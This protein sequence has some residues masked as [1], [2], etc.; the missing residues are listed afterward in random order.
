MSRNYINI[1]E[2]RQL[3]HRIDMKLITPGRKIDKQTK[4]GK[5]QSKKSIYGWISLTYSSSL[6]SSSSSPI[7]ES[8]SGENTE[9][10]KENEDYIHTNESLQFRLKWRKQL[11]KSKTQIFR[12]K[13]HIP[14][15]SACC[16]SSRGCS[17]PFRGRRSAA[18]II[19]SPTKTYERKESLKRF[20]T[21]RAT[22]RNNKY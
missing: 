5:S 18:D 12:G 19:L 8:D 14:T 3:N 16:T 1:I 7:E 11:R 17:W 13:F 2:I 20:A 22:M 21:S 4:K 9:K 10:R 6:S 15:P